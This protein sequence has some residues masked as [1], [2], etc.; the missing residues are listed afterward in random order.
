MIPKYEPEKDFYYDKKQT[1]WHCH[2]SGLGSNTIVKFVN[3]GGPFKKGEGYAHYCPNCNEYMYGSYRDNW[4][5]CPY[6]DQ[7]L[8]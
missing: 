7:F 2:W 5:K 4:V 8:P 6:C 3:N 1:C